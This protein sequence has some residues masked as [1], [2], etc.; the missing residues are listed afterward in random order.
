MTNEEIL[1]KQVEALEKLLQLKEAVITE[2]EA[3]VHRLQYPYGVGGGIGGGLVY[4]PGVVYGGGGAQGIAGQGGAGF[5]GGGAISIPSVW[6]S[7]QPQYSWSATCPDG[8]SHQM[9]TSNCCTKCGQYMV[10]GGTIVGSATT[11]IV[12]TTD[13]QGGVT[14]GQT[15]SA[16]QSSTSDLMAI[17]MAG[18]PKTNDQ[19]SDN[20]DPAITA[21]NN[22]FALT[23]SK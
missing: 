13:A 7:P 19:G 5:G 22:V 4:Q 12:T 20:T 15:G 1:E 10:G 6:Q 16:G 17:L 3:K 8:S 2:L 23:S 11:G 18:M 14:V 9:G 21:S